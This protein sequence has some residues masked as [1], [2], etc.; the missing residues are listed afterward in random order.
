MSEKKEKKSFKWIFLLQQQFGHFDSL[1]VRSLIGVAVTLIL[2]LFLHFKQVDVEILELDTIAKR[3]HVAQTNFTY[4]DENITALNQK[5]ALESIGGLYEITPTQVDEALSDYEKNLHFDTALTSEQIRQYYKWA[6]SFSKLLKQVRFADRNTIQSLQQIKINTKKILVFHTRNNKTE[7]LPRGIYMQLFSMAKVDPNAQASLLKYYQSSRWTFIEDGGL[8]DKVRSRILQSIPKGKAHVS[9]GSRI[10]DQG[11]RVSSKHV[12]MMQGMK[13]AMLE[14]RRLWHA[15]TLLGSLLLSILFV[16]ITV[17]YFRLKYPDLLR[18]TKQLLLYVSVIIL[19]LLIAKSVE[20]LLLEHRF[21]LI[22]VVRY[23]LF[24]PFATILFCFLIGIELAL[25]TTVLLS[26]IFSITLAVDETRFL[27]VNLVASMICLFN[28]RFVRKR[29]EIFSICGRAWLSCIVVIFGF[30]LLDGIW[31]DA[32][33]YSDIIS[34]LLFMLITSILCIGL[35][36]LLESMFQIMTNITLMEYLD[37][38]HPLLRR[39]SIEA[40]GTYQHTLLTAN[41]AESAA[42]AI[43]ANGIF[44]R[45]ATMYHDIGKL[46]NPQYFT[47]NQQAGFNMHQLLTPEESAAVIIEHVKAGETLARKYRLPKIFINIIREHHGTTLVRYF[48]HKMLEKVEG[49]KSKVDESKFRYSGPKPRTKESAI[50]MI[51]DTFEAASRSLTE[52]TPETVTELLESLVQHKAQDG[53]FD[54]CPITF[55]ELGLIKSS[56]IKNMLVTS[57]TRVKYPKDEGEEKPSAEDT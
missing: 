51:A 40:P 26:V 45:V 50:I 47:E 30:S 25:F 3:Y 31:W 48:Y 15:S 17:V 1:G 34:T 14:D 8:Q 52:F 29:T 16:T 7:K 46:F 4:H 36:P 41:F 43:N 44:C 56:L 2:A 22:D 18:N 13:K 55:E 37:P 57:H 21:H 32:S 38:N 27:V 12:A 33:I 9:A 5:Q 6:E 24:I 23:P 19:A 42:L 54:N 35:L 20:M 10:I 39:L 11:E 53:Q 49:D 28:T